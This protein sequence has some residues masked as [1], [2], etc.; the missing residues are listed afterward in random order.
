[1]LESV[2]VLSFPLLSLFSFLL[3]VTSLL[4]LKTNFVFHHYLGLNSVGKEVRNMGVDKHKKLIQ[5]KLAFAF[6]HSS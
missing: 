1:M 5:V 2:L 6:F 3:S 4:E